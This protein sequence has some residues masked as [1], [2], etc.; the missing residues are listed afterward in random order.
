MKSLILT[1]LYLAK[2][3]LHRWCAR[4]SSPVAR[5]LVVFFLTLA[6]LA[7]LIMSFEA[8]KLRK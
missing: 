1:I 4:I 6:A 3:T 7:C 8:K 2:D 5:V